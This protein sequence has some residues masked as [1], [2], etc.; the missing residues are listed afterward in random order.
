MPWAQETGC[1]SCVTRR[2]VQ[3]R[4]HL[5]ARRTVTRARI[6]MHSSLLRGGAG[7][8]DG[9]SVDYGRRVNLHGCFLAR[10]LRSASQF[11]LGTNFT[12]S[13]HTFAHPRV[14][15]GILA[16]S[17]LMH[18]DCAGGAS[19]CPHGRIFDNLFPLLAEF[20]KLPCRGHGGCGPVVDPVWPSPAPAE[21]RRSQGPTLLAHSLTGPS[22]TGPTAHSLIGPSPTGPTAHS[23]TDPSPT[24]PIALTRRSRNRSGSWSDLPMP[25]A[26]RC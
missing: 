14:T 10:R 7:A 22:P 19:V 16:A 8:S 21:R 3:T 26:R 4:R 20:L 2:G 24:C 5:H 18:G 15:S 12:A 25:A 17:G 13:A 1:W 23:P 11:N 9:S 6:R